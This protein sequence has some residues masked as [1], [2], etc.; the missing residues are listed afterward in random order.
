MKQ[1]ARWETF[2]KEELPELSY[3]DE[4]AATALAERRMRVVQEAIDASVAKHEML[5]PRSV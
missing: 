1:L 2:L 3:E 4:A 5:S